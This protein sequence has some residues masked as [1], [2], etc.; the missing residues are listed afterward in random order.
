MNDDAA[1]DDDVKALC[2][3]S[4][5]MSEAEYPSTLQRWLAPKITRVLARLALLEAEHEAW[6]VCQEATIAGLHPGPWRR[7][8][9]K[10]HAAAEEAMKR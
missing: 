4:E 10:A 7:T 6:K 9:R 3:A 8:H 2:E 1:L 5:L